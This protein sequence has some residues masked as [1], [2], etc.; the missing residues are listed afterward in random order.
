MCHIITCAFLLYFFNFQ[1]V[2]SGDVHGRFELQLS[3]FTNDQAVD[4]QEQ[5]CDGS[6]LVGECSTTTPCD[7]FFRICLLNFMRDIPMDQQCTFGSIITPVLGEN[8]FLIPNGPM[9]E[10]NFYNPLRIDFRFDW[11]VSTIIKKSYSYLH[12]LCF[13]TSKCFYHINAM[14]FN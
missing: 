10:E 1:A 13:M 11:P 5:C 14:N 4:A 3:S 9:P 7:T 6:G 2:L 12:T 8:S